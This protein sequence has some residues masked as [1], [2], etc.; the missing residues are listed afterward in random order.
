MRQWEYMVA[1]WDRDKAGDS[2]KPRSVEIGIGLGST[3]L[4]QIGNGC[5]LS[6]ALNALG[7]AGWEIFKYEEKRVEMVVS[8]RIETHRVVSFIAKKEKQA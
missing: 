2:G 1:E 5:G 4:F 3:N 7:R 8:G 6:D